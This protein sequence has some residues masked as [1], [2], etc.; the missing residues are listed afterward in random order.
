[1]ILVVDFMVVNL[2]VLP[3]NP[4]AK[5]ANVVLES[6]ARARSS[7]SGTSGRRTLMLVGLLPVRFEDLG[8]RCLTSSNGLP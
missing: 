5:G 8:D 1:M 6:R 3:V 4:A 2:P 7:I